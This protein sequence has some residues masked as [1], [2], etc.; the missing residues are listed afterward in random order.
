M[1]AET[2]GVRVIAHVVGQD[3]YAVPP[4]MGVGAVAIGGHHSTHLAVVEGEGAEELGDEIVF[5]VLSPSHRRH[6][7]SGL[8][9]V[10]LLANTL[11]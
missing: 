4:V 9:V 8:K 10:H 3:D 1:F 11:T 7:I 2:A 6:I 5:M